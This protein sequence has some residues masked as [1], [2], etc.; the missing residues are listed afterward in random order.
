M[1][2]V[3]ASDR[4]ARDGRHGAPI[5]VDVA[6]AYGTGHHVE[7]RGTRQI[8]IDTRRSGGWYDLTL[9]TPSDPSF[10]A[11]IAGR[12]ESRGRLTSDPQ[13]GRS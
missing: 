9:T 10:L 4:H 8:T 7:L 3:T 6:D 2:A 12:V 5:D 1:T 13:L 11:Q